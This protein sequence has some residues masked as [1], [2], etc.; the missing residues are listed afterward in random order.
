[1]NNDTLARFFNIFHQIGG[2]FSKVFSVNGRNHI[3]EP[4]VEIGVLQG[5]CILVFCAVIP[6]LHKLT[7]HLRHVKQTVKVQSLPL[8]GTLPYPDIDPALSVTELFETVPQALFEAF[9]RVF[10][11]VIG[12]RAKI[13]P[14][15][16]MDLSRQPHAPCDKI[17]LYSFHLLGYK[18]RSFVFIFKVR[19]QFRCDFGDLFSLSFCF[20]AFVRRFKGF[21][22]SCCPCR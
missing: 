3:A 5:H 16:K 18:G 8:W 21:F 19:S 22:F 13:V 6:M 12:E 14:V 1:M 15:A 9:F 2:G 17:S 7:L 20:R 11:I 4:R 10:F